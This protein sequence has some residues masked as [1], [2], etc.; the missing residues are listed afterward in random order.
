MCQICCW[1][2]YTAVGVYV[3]GSTLREAWG[4]HAGQK[5]REFNSYLKVCFHVLNHFLGIRSVGSVLSVWQILCDNA[6]HL[7]LGWFGNNH[8]ICAITNLL[9]V[10]IC[11]H[12]S[13]AELVKKA[14]KYDLKVQHH[15]DVVVEVEWLT[16]L[17]LQEHRICVGMELVTAVLGDHGQ[18][19]LHDYG[20]FL[21]S[22]SLFSLSVS[23]KIL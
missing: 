7:D 22:A 4:P 1:H 23:D 11:S 6:I 19:P 15:L 12:S 18:R 10:L 17:V 16:Y 5:Q 9:L 2:R 14:T 13:S 8:S 20:T 21:F 3:L